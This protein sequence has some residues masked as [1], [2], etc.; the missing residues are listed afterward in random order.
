ML[1]GPEAASAN[2]ARPWAAALFLAG[3]LLFLA[4]FALEAAADRAIRRFRENP[5]NA[6]RLLVEGLHARVR[7]PNYLGEIVLQ[8]GSA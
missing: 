1:A 4:G 6:G 2:L 7:H 5:A 3:A 8:W